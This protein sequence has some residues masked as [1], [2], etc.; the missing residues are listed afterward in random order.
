MAKIEE[1]VGAGRP[2]RPK[3]PFEFGDM[4]YKEF[5]SKL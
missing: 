3:V 2:K 5:K 1:E 4:P